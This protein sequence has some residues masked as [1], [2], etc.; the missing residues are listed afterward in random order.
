[1]FLDCVRECVADV[2]S[3]CVSECVSVS[4][5]MSLE[6]VY[7]CVAY[8]F[9]V[10]VSAVC[11]CVADVSFECVWVCNR[12]L[13]RVRLCRRCRFSVCVS[14]LHMS[15]ECVSLSVWVCCECLLSEFVSA[16]QMSFV[17]VSL[18]CAGVLRMSFECVCECVT[19]VLWVCVPWVCGRVA[20]VAWVFVRVQIYCIFTFWER[21]CVCSLRH[22]IYLHVDLHVW[23][24]QDYGVATISRL[25]KIIGL[26]CKR[27]LSK[28]RFSAKETYNFKEPTNRSQ[29]ILRVWVMCHMNHTNKSCFIEVRHVSYVRVNPD[30]F[31]GFFVSKKKK[32][33]LLCS[34]TPIK[35]GGG[36]LFTIT[37][38]VGRGV[39]V[40]KIY[41]DKYSNKRAR[42]IL[43]DS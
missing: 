36:V 28:R 39:F 15:F 42:L 9:W 10:C 41:N 33:Y 29:P 5:R 37:T 19:H 3:V 25:L 11:E 38:A 16:L 43:W 4:Q 6:C 17:C 12:C 18:Q 40:I 30:A 13:L 27:A 14:V 23:V 21:E 2:F 35:W 34:K 24:I 26:L 31:L 20:D 32:D 8:V 22:T 1:M 7:E